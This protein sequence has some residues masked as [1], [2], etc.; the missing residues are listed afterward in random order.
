MEIH[1]I[2]GII[3]VPVFYTEA[4]TMGYS[5][6]CWCLFI[7][8]RPEKRGKC[9]ILEHELVHCK[10][11]YRSLGFYPLM[12]S[13]SRR[14]RYKSEIEAYKEQIRLGGATIEEAANWIIKNYGITGLL[15]ERVK[16][17]LQQN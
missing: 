11:F 1:W 4:L 13:I 15:K 14:Y 2:F 12:Y 5:A 8:V 3:P 7:V 10:Q 17:D 16:N 6:F 9:K